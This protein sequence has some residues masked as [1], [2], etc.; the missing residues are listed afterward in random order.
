MSLFLYFPLAS[1]LPAI[2]IM[3]ASY[4]GCEHVLVIV[5]FIIAIGMHG[6]LTA[7]LNTNSMDLCP[8]YSGVLM[9]VAN[10]AASI[11]GILAPYTISLM[12]PNVNQILK[13]FRRREIYSIKLI[14]TKKGLSI[15]MASCVLG[16]VCHSHFEDHNFYDLGLRR[17]TAVER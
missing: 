6:F 1:A 11:T 8:N 12:T 10:G 14:S 9:S 5:F 7:G 15:G 2:F 4:A 16:Y 13:S 3:L 17:N